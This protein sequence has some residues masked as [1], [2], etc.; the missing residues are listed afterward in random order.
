LG[1]LGDQL[2][3]ETNV[4]LFELSCFF[5]ECLFILN[6]LRVPFIL[7]TLERDTSFIVTPYASIECVAIDLPHML[8]QSEYL[9]TGLK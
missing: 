9:G 6:N 8:N 3:G 7:E 4:F 5:S 2:L 1:S